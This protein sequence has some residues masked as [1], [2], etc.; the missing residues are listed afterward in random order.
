LPSLLELKQP[1]FQAFW[2]FSKGYL[3]GFQVV[4]AGVINQWNSEGRFSWGKQ[5][6]LEDFLPSGIGWWPVVSKQR[7]AVSIKRP[8]F[9]IRYSPFLLFS[10]LSFHLLDSRPRQTA[11]RRQ[12]FWVSFF[13]IST[14]SEP[15][16]ARMLISEDQMT[17]L[18]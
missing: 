4:F 15:G 14:F 13:K 17:K 6:F 18:E 9:V 1:G 3:G 2:T 16:I 10:H 8:S 11:G 7:S 5:G 12:I